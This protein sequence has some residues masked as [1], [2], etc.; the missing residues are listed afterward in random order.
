MCEMTW[1]DQRKTVL[2]IDLRNCTTWEDFAQAHDEAATLL[3]RSHHTVHRIVNMGQRDALPLGNPWTLLR[4]MKNISAK[5][6]GLVVH[7]GGSVAADM[8]RAATNRCLPDHIRFVD[9]V[10]EAYR[11]CGLGVAGIEQGA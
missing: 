4:R 3:L 10:A 1:L 7:V 11:L 6:S 5:N 8:M 9:T 2:Q